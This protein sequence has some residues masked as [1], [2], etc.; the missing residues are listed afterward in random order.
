MNITGQTVDKMKNHQMVWEHW[1]DW[2]PSPWAGLC[3]RVQ[4]ATGLIGSFSKPR[5]MGLGQTLSRQGIN[6]FSF[7]LLQNH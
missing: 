1:K 3:E 4:R 2:S 5:S 7:F 6:R